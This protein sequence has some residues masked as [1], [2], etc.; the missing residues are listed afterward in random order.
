MAE[1]TRTR[2]PWV[3]WWAVVVLLL[4]ALSLAWRDGSLGEDPGTIAVAIVIMMGYV[5]TGAIVASRSR[6]RLGWLMIAVG[7]GFVVSVV[8]QETATYAF[9]TA[10]GTLPTF[11]VDAALVGSNVG[12]L[13]AVWPIPMILALF[14]TGHVPSRRWRWYP[15]AL[16]VMFVLGAIG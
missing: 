16:S 14:P 8:C 12:F 15:H 11:L 1:R 5:T 7:A 9:R 3:V 4:L 6:N 2:A 13:A 10:P